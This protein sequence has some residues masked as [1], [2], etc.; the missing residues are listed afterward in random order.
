[1]IILS[2]LSILCLICPVISI[3]MATAHPQF[4]LVWDRLEDIP[5]LG[6]ISHV[7]ARSVGKEIRIYSTRFSQVL[8]KHLATETEVQIVDGCVTEDAVPV[9]EVIEA[10]LEILQYRKILDTIL[11][12]WRNVLLGQPVY[13]EIHNLLYERISLIH[14]DFEQFIYRIQAASISMFRAMNKELCSNACKDRS[15]ILN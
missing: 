13:P 4:K 7:L 12:R 10:E 6:Q 11:N 14:E 1:M 2:S 3:S 8:A 9:L 15:K 5:T